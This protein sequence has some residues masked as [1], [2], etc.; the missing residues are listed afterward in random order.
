MKHKFYFLYDMILVAFFSFRTLLRN[1]SHGN[2]S[3]R[4]GNGKKVK[5]EGVNFGNFR[6]EGNLVIRHDTFSTA[7]RVIGRRQL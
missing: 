6:M 5:N 1:I 2:Q 7:L 4:K 3:I